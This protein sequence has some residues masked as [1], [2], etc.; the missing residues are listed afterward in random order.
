M[1]QSPSRLVAALVLAAGSSRRFGSDKRQELIADGSRVL[2]RSCA[3]ACQAFADVRVVLREQDD[4]AALGLD[5]RI[6]VVHSPQA[7]LGMG[8]SLASG[9][10]ALAESD[11]EA[12][13]ILLGDMPWLNP[14][15]LVQLAALAGPQN[16]VVPMHEGQQGHPVIIGRQ[17][18]PQLQ[19][20][21]GDRGA[22]AL[23]AAHS[24]CCV[25]IETGDRGILLDAD[26]PEALAQALR[27]HTC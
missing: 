22:K 1:H 17:F 15:T 18:W 4:P 6:R 2:Q 11:A 7:T 21:S 9:V 20:L 24:D 5:T 26:T 3:N 25:R 8:H 27:D 14:V 23:L 19:Q 12:V 10:T 13:A 16:I